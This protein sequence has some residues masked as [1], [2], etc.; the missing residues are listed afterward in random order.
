MDKV[1]ALQDLA[2][3]QL[4]DRVLYHEIRITQKSAQIMVHIGEDHEH[5]TTLRP[6]RSIFCSNVSVEAQSLLVKESNSLRSTTMS[7]ISTMLG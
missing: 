2:E 3:E 4:G 5:I 7:M 6:V 1:H